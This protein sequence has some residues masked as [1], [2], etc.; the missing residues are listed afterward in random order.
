MDNQLDTK[1]KKFNKHITKSLNEEYDVDVIV[2]E[3]DIINGQITVKCDLL[4]LVCIIYLNIDKITFGDELK[5][6]FK[7]V[8]K[9]Y[10]GLFWAGAASR[11]AKIS[12]QAPAV[13]AL[14]HK[15]IVKLLVFVK[16][17]LASFLILT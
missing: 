4:T 6:R 13:F 11:L 5:I 9:K 12:S 7:F 3:I 16:F 15:E 17:R 14:N 8:V 1:L 2:D 10:P